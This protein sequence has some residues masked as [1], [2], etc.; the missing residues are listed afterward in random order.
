MPVARTW[1][2]DVAAPGRALVQRRA[3]RRRFEVHDRSEF[4]CL[5]APFARVCLN[6]T[7]DMQA[8]NLEMR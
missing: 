3:G 5:Q 7:G 6:P 1:D 8:R 2:E 4:V